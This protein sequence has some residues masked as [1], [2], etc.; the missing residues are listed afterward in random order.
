MVDG[1]VKNS[2]EKRSIFTFT[3]WHGSR[4]LGS[5]PT[6]WL[7]TICPLNFFNRATGG[8][9]LIVKTSLPV[10]AGARSAALAAGL[11]QSVPSL[12]A[13]EVNEVIG[14]LGADLVYQ[15]QL[16]LIGVGVMVFAGRCSLAKSILDRPHPLVSLAMTTYRSLMSI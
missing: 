7:G 16:G 11:I 3:L 10:W 15:K 8:V 14:G 13:S 6:D 4:H 12:Q 9:W 2:S 5:D 1:G